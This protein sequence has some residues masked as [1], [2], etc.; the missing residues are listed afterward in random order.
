MLSLETKRRL[1]FPRDETKQFIRVGLIFIIDVSASRR[2]FEG[3]N[4]LVGNKTQHDLISMKT[5]NYS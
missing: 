1:N 5:K 3:I 4:F 2:K